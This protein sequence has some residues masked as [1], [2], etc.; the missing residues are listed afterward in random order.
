RVASLDLARSNLQRGVELLPSGGISKEELD[1]RRQS[2]KVAEA[3]VDQALQAIYASRVGL[4][5]PAHPPVGK[6]LG[7]APADLSE[8][9]SAVR[10]ALGVLIESAASLGYSPAKFEAT[11]TEAVA[12]FKKQDPKGDVEKI[13]AKLIPL[14]PAIKQAEAKLLEA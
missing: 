3:A 13:Y 4:G 11:P 6:D 7:Y 14:A 2:V 9:Y 12:A 10:Q 5:L 8:T 1:V